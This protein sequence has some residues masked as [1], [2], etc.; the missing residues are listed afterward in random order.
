[1]PLK[2]ETSLK[3][4]GL[5]LGVFLIVG[6]IISAIGIVGGALLDRSF[7]FPLDVWV[8]VNLPVLAMVADKTVPAK[9]KFPFGREAQQ[10]D[11]AHSQKPEVYLKSEPEISLGAL[12]SPEASKK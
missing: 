8:G 5:T 9:K 6:I 1:M 7:L 10:P 4:I 12:T 2:P 11:E 3:K